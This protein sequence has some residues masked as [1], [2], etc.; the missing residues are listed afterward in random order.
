VNQSDNALSL[1]IPLSKSAAVIERIRSA[2]NLPS[3]PGVALEVLRLAENP[4]VTLEQMARTIEKDPALT[5]KILKIV[6]SPLFGVSNKIASLSQAVGMLGLRTVKIMA[7][8]F[9]VV[10]TLQ[11]TQSGEFDFEAFW[12]RS[13]TTAVAARLLGQAMHRA[14]AEEAFV[15]GLLADVG[16]IAAWKCAPTEYVPVLLESVLTTKPI[17]QIEEGRLGVTH[18]FLSREMLQGWG[19]PDNLCQAIGAHH[20]EGLA[21]LDGATGL[22]AKAVHSAGV[23]ADLFC[24][25]TPAD[26]LD[27]ARSECL[28]E[29]GINPSGFE[30]LLEQLDEQVKQSASVLELDIGTTISYG[31]LRAQAALQ[32]AQISMQADS[33]VDDAVK[34]EEAARAELSQ[35]QVK[36]A[37]DGLTGVWNRAAILEFLEREFARS[38]RQGNPVAVVLA[39]LDQ[40]KRINDTHGHLTGDAVLREAAHRMHSSIRRYDALGRYGG[41]EFML[42]LTDCD[43]SQ[44]MMIAERARENVGANPVNT[45][46]ELIPVTVSLG[47]SVFESGKGVSGELLLEIAD[48]ALYR[49]KESGRNRT[50]LG[51]L[52]RLR[53]KVGVSNWLGHISAE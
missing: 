28:L 40:F 21:D 22:L 50:E 8:S 16:M 1:E 29:C 18:A 5:I 12:R 3:I 41:E 19:L 11:E 42:V 31:E 4:D 34:K 15:A 7:L 35:L 25:Q 43:E 6:N 10:E 13:L 52:V 36:A 33:Q 39:D 14:L 17:T 45:P 23:I 46:N 37:T 27:R 47:V 30:D 20:G 53:E 44:A 24:H 49:A 26:E 2:D 32:I 9:S 51:E 38:A 48:K